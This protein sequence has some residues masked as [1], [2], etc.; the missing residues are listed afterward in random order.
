M[1]LRDSVTALPL[2]TADSQHF[3]AHFKDT[4]TPVRLPCLGHVAPFTVI[5]QHLLRGVL[6]R[7][8]DISHRRLCAAGGRARS[9]AAATRLD[10]RRKRG[11]A[12]ASS[13]PGLIAP[14]RNVA[15][16]SSLVSGGDPASAAQSCSRCC[17]RF[18]AR[19]V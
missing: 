19:Q 5:P 7:F 16:Q 11:N 15:I 18:R 3:A 14:Y 8:S 12:A 13:L 6:D 9:A 2:F 4:Q 17:E 10:D 1:V